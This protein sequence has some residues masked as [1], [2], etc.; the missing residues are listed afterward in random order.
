MMSRPRTIFQ[1]GDFTH[2]AEEPAG[3]DERKH[4]VM[5]PTHNLAMYMVRNA[6]P[7]EVGLGERHRV[8]ATLKLH[9]E[10]V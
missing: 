6:K 10:K 3:F 4:F 9:G 7:E 1:C 8:V 2:W 5:C